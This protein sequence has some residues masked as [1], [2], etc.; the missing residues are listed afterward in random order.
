MGATS[1][2]GLFPP[3]DRK[4]MRCHQ[5]VAFRYLDEQVFRYNNRKELDD[6]GRFELKIKLGGG[7]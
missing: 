1:T 2:S 4:A 7:K 6:A 5:A 3:N